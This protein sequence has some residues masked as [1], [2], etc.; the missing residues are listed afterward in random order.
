ML[1]H[2]GSTTATM[3]AHE[4]SVSMSAAEAE[5]YAMA[6][7]LVE[8]KQVLEILCEYHENT[9]II[10]ELA[11]E[12]N[13]ER[14]GCGR[15]NQHNR[16]VTWHLTTR[17]ETCLFVIRWGIILIDDAVITTSAVDFLCF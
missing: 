7:E 9:H 12:T 10:L 15:M 6:S 11:S 1:K 13:A 4:T 8:A 16:T 2:A 17:V 5:Y 14:P 3:T